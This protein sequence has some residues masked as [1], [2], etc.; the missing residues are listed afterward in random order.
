MRRLDFLVF[1]QKLV[2]RISQLSAAFAKVSM[3]MPT[4]LDVSKLAAYSVARERRQK[5]VSM[6]IAAGFSAPM[7]LPL[8]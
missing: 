5:D 3:L 7:L 1:V 2:H 6:T 8:H 4:T